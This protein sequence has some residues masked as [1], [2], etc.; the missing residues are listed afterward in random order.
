MFL[1]LLL[2]I[3]ISAAFTQVNWKPYLTSITFKIKNAGI[4]TNGSFKGFSGQLLFDENRPE[5]SSFS[6]S[7]LVSTI[8]TGIELRDEHLKGEKYF[9]AEKY[10]TIE[11]KSTK[12]YRS[13]QGFEGS[14]NVTIKGKTL[15]VVIP[16]TFTKNNEGAIF[17]GSFTINRRDFDIGG[18][19]LTLSDNADVTIIVHA[20]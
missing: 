2:S 11:V 15:P 1:S 5:N 14:F 17:E 7:V 12:I 13:K 3:S 6:A 19:S 10:K 16:F 20:K 18:S 8:S 9:D 4:T